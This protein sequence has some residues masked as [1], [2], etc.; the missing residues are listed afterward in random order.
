MMNK[1]KWSIDPS[2]SEIG[3]KIEHL[4]ISH[5]KGVFLKFDSDISTIGEDFSTAEINVWIEAASLDTRDKKR[6]EHLK[7]PDFFDV[8]KFK[9]ITFTGGEMKKSSKT[10]TFDLTGDLKMRGITKQIKLSVTYGGKMKDPYGNDKAG[11]IVT[12]MINR[13]DWELGWNTP[14]TSGG[15]LLDDEVH[16]NCEVQLIKKSSP[17]IKMEAEN[18]Q[19]EEMIA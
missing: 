1:T 16:L 15:V 10:G 8:D 18:T 14:L 2:H 7:G 3:F 11:F 17:E 9:E 19:S 4:M 13:K 5:V 12:G 6:D